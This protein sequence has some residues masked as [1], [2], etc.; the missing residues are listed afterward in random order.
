MNLLVRE[1]PFVFHG[2]FMKSVHDLVHDYKAK[3]FKNRLRNQESHDPETCMYH[4]GLDVYRVSITGDPELIL[5]YFT[6][7]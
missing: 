4:W 7:R 3:T 1:L 2:L 6:A 5:T